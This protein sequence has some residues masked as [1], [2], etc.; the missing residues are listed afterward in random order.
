MPSNIPHYSKTKQPLEKY[1]KAMRSPI[2][3]Q[4]T[5]LIIHFGKQLSDFIFNIRKIVLGK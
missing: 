2:T 3:D 1:L 5:I 4:D